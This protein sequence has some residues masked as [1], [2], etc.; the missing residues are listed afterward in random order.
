MSF[1]DNGDP[2]AKYELVNWQKSESGSIDLVTVGHYDALLPVGQEFCINRNLTWVEG[3]TQVAT[4][5]QQCDIKYPL[6]HTGWE[7]IDTWHNSDLKDG[8]QNLQF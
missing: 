6:I 4:Q 8:E 3:G 7:E 5:K 2:V 1:D